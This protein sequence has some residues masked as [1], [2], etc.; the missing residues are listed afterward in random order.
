MMDQHRICRTD[1]ETTDINRYECEDVDNADTDEEEDASQADD[2]SM[3][4]VEE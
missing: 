4:N 2:G 3:H 1:L